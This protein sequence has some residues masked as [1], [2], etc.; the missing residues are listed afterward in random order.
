MAESPPSPRND[1]TSTGNQDTVVIKIGHT[2]GYIEFAVPVALCLSAASVVVEWLTQVCDFFEMKSM[3]IVIAKCMDQ[4]S[5][6]YNIK[7]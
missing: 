2:R 4:I 1:A 3:F 6:P 5:I 7:I